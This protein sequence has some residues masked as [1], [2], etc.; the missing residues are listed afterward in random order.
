MRSKHAGRRVKCPDCETPIPI[1]TVDEY[2]KRQRDKELMA[3]TQPEELEPYKVEAPTQRPV[4]KMTYTSQKAVVHRENQV[5]ELPKP[6]KWLFFSDVFNLPWQT[7][8][9]ALRWGWMSAGLTFS[10]VLAALGALVVAAA[11]FLGMIA[12]LFFTMGVAWFAAW[13]LAYA[14]SCAFCIIL[15]TSSGSKMVESWPDGGFRDWMMDFLAT[16]YVAVVS[17]FIAYVLSIPLG[18]VIGIA[19]PDLAA[20]QMHLFALHALLFPVAFLGALD[21]ESIWIPLSG[22]IN[23][24]LMRIPH[25]WL[26]F[27]VVAGAAWGIGIGIIMGLALVLPPA[28]LLVGGPIVGALLWISARLLGRLA[29][30]INDDAGRV[31]DGDEDDD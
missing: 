21:A 18:L 7:K 17:G 4:M 11:G 22:T 3:P 8:K 10:T 15:D 1:P 23:R 19:F 31:D 9:T 2:L 24:S 30:K 20:T 29:W 12:A 28:G 16:L 6:P 25:W 26:L 13:A 5:K 14:A 27:Y